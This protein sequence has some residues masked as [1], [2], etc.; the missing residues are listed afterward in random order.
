MGGFREMISGYD[1]KMQKAELIAR[2]N[3]G[4]MLNVHDFM[5][6]ADD[7]KEA[8]LLIRALSCQRLHAPLVALPHCL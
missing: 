6:P 1:T 2:E 3:A 4:E 8:E 7:E 5:P